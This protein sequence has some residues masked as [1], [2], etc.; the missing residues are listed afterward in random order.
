MGQICSGARKAEAKVR[1]RKI[2][3]EDNEF[4]GV[5]FVLVKIYY[6]DLNPHAFHRCFPAYRCVSQMYGW[7][8][9]TRQ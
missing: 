8:S 3:D 6:W 1:V 9:V 4:T 5:G 7:Q 2:I